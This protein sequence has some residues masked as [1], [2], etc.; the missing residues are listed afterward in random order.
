MINNIYLRKL[1]DRI[2]NAMIN[3]DGLDTDVFDEETMTVYK[4][5][6]ERCFEKFNTISDDEIA[7]R[8]NQ[9]DNFYD[10]LIKYSNTFTYDD[11]CQVVSSFDANNIEH[12]FSFNNVDREYLLSYDLSV[13]DPL[14]K[15]SNPTEPIV[16][17]G[18]EEYV[19][20]E[21]ID[22]S[23]IVVVIELYDE[24]NGTGV[25]SYCLKITMPF[26]YSTDLS[27]DSVRSVHKNDKIGISLYSLTPVRLFG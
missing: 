20:G 27:L 12:V 26:S 13:Y 21:S 16:V 10:K 11:E 18:A 14:N 24:Y 25:E 5:M 4:S 22:R 6:I 19:N 23:I 2:I 17:D 7:D 3:K 8:L 15:E 1:C 9:C